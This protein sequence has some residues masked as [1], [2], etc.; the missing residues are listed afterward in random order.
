MGAAFE[1][2]ETGELLSPLQ[3]GAHPPPVAV[4]PEPTVFEKVA[5]SRRRP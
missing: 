2:P 5:R 3:W 1:Y 4:Q